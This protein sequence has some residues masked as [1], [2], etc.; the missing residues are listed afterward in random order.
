MKVNKTFDTRLEALTG[1]VSETPKKIETTN[2]YLKPKSTQKVDPSF[3]PASHLD[4]IPDQILSK[5]WGAMAEDAISY[6]YKHSNYISSRIK[7]FGKTH[8]LQAAV[9]L[10]QQVANEVQSEVLTLAIKSL[11][12]SKQHLAQSYAHLVWSEG[13]GR[14]IIALTNTDFILNDTGEG[15]LSNT[16]ERTLILDVLTGD[17][18]WYHSLGEHGVYHNR[19][20]KAN[21]SVNRLHHE[22]RRKIVQNSKI[23]K[24]IQTRSF[25][26]Y[27]QLL[28][29]DLITGTHPNV[30]FK[31]WMLGRQYMFLA[32][33]IIHE[34]LN[35]REHPK[36]YND[37]LNSKGVEDIKEVCKRWEAEYTNDTGF[38]LCS[39]H[40]ATYVVEFTDANSKKFIGNYLCITNENL[41]RFKNENAT[42]FD[43]FN[44]HSYGVLFDLNSKKYWIPRHFPMGVPEKLFDKRTIQYPAPYMI[45]SLEQPEF[46]PNR[47]PKNMGII[48]KLNDMSTVINTGSMNVRFD[49]VYSKERVLQG[50]D[51]KKETH[52]RRSYAATIALIELRKNDRMIQ[53]FAESE[54]CFPLAFDKVRTSMVMGWL[55]LHL[56]EGKDVITRCK[57]PKTERYQTDRCLLVIGDKPVQGNGCQGGGD[58]GDST[59]VFDLAPQKP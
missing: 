33:Q 14:P 58:I 23:K 25:V 15:D 8:S 40:V 59:L 11:R 2:A 7:K 20:F 6:A 51:I 28:K 22:S 43:L 57:R 30:L 32:E 21:V 49:S 38:P 45:K 29:T 54:G 36:N 46:N 52:L 17:W 42:I 35:D 47:M 4:N 3:E 5:H 34:L 1:K 27:H 41:G 19:V 16:W 24:C 56:Q 39:Y 48:K 44:K 31:G 50:Q 53:M 26:P 37:L 18:Y 55:K 12:S 9:L 10:K 13:L